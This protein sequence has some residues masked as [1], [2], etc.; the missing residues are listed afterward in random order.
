MSAEVVRAALDE[1]ISFL[2]CPRLTEELRGVLARDR[3][4]AYLS[5][6]EADVLAD[7]IEA[8]SD[9]VA[10]PDPVPPATRD[11]AD[12]YLIALARREEVDAII[13]GD[14]DLA[15]E[16]G[17]PVLS[18]REVLDE[19]SLD[20]AHRDLLVSALWNLHLRITEAT[21]GSEDSV[22]TSF[23]EVM[24]DAARKLGGDPEAPLFGL[25]DLPEEGIDVRDL[26]RAERTA[27][28][29]A[30]EWDRRVSGRLQ[31][32]HAEAA[33]VLRVAFDI[34]DRYEALERLL[35]GAR[36]SPSGS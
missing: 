35:R 6:E 9:L 16:G 19:L 4:R 15:V 14:P 32:E 24:H 1:V 2:A 30:L 27:C 22:F 34:L 20:P 23:L 12:D 11:P 29:Y 13:S 36:G 26:T 33:E 28:A 25:P 31:A 7:A 5:R 21:S 8:A 3:F 17:P 10:D 18:P